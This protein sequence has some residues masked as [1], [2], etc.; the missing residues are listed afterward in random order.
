MSHT[1]SQDLEAC[2]NTLQSNL[3]DTQQEVKQLSANIATINKNMQSSINASIE[4]IKQDMNNH[5]EF[6]VSMIDTKLHIPAD[7]PLSDPPLHT[8]AETSSHSHIFILITFS[9]TYTF[10]GWM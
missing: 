6:V 4:E 9:M 5:L 10:H 2:F 1:H 8:E 7:T 3:T